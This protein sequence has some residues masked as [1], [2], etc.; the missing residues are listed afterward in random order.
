M[1]GVTAMGVNRLVHC[2]FSE[3][4]SW[5]YTDRKKSLKRCLTDTQGPEFDVSRREHKVLTSSYPQYRGSPAQYYTNG[6]NG[7]L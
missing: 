4:Q 3:I 7:S 5:R 1:D 6:N 2:S